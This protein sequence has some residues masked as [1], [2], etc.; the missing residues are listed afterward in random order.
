[1][2]CTGEVLTNWLACILRREQGVFGVGR[3]LEV[4]LCSGVSDPRVCIYDPWLGP[5]PLPRRPPVFVQIPTTTGS[6]GVLGEGRGM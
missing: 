6:P 3:T 1:M 2:F 5:T 4:H